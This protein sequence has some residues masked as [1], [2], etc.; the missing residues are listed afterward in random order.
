MAEYVQ[1]GKLVASF[2][3][4]GELILTHALGQVPKPGAWKVLFLEPKPG[5]YLPYFITHYQAKKPDELLLQ[6]EGILTPEAARPLIRKT[7]WVTAETFRE[8]A[9]PS[10][11]ISLLGFTLFDGK[12]AL[13]EVEEVIEQPHQ[14]ICVIRI[15]GKEVLIPVHESSLKKIDIKARRVVVELPDGLLD[16]YLNP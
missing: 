11:A 12:T 10:A 3:L 14:I 6:L 2:G 8:L 1:V 16:V 15:E 7:V 5:S 4:K 9:A 13:G